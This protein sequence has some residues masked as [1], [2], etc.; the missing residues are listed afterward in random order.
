M[1]SIGNVPTVICDAELKVTSSAATLSSCDELIAAPKA[2]TKP[3]PAITQVVCVFSI[4][5]G[6]IDEKSWS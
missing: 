4:V 5:D 2:V 1:P 6:V 3:P